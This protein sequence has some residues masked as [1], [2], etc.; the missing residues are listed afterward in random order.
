[1]W[2]VDPRIVNNVLYVMPINHEIDFAWQAQY[3]VRLE[4]HACCS[5]HCK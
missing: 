3:L 5:A 4:G 1:M 2:T